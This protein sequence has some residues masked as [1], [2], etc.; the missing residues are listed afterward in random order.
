MQCKDSMSWQFVQMDTRKHLGTIEIDL[1]QSNTPFASVNGG[2]FFLEE[3]EVLF[4]MHTEFRIHDIK[5][6]AINNQ[7]F[8]LTLTLTNDEDKDLRAVADSIL[9]KNARSANGWYRLGQVLIKMAY[10]AQEIYEVLLDQTMDESEKGSIYH[11]LGRINGSQGKHHEAIALYKKAIVVYQRTTNSAHIEI[12]N[13]RMVTQHKL[14][15]YHPDVDGSYNN[16]GMTYEEMSDYLEA[17]SFYKHAV[18]V[19]RSE[20]V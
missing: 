11:E 20:D 19:G 18:E 2:S 16:V 12:E 13:F 4:S 15:A 8:E 10:K 17:H 14:S 5:A 6:S 9:K 7:F 3:D 1:A